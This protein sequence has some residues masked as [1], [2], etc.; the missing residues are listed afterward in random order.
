MKHKVVASR[1]CPQ[2]FLSSLSCHI[3][4]GFEYK[5]SLEASHAHTD[6]ARNDTDEWVV[7]VQL[8][9]D[10]IMSSTNRLVFMILDYSNEVARSH[11]VAIWN[12]AASV[13]LKKCF[14]WCQAGML[15]YLPL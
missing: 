7:A 9:L 8:K 1:I 12:E 11:L 13:R 4:I 14:E 6:D 3:S 15:W 2:S 5:G 10:L